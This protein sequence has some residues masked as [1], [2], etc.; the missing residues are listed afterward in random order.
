MPQTQHITLPQNDPFAVAPQAPLWWSLPIF[1]LMLPVTLIGVFLAVIACIT[2]V[3]LFPFL[4]GKLRDALAKV[5]T[6]TL[7]AAVRVRMRVIDHNPDPSHHAKLFVAPHIFMFEAI[8]MFRIVGHIR[9]LAAAFVKTIPVFN[10]V[11]AAV[12]PIYVGRS[13]GGNVV[14]RLRESLE[15]TDYRHAIFPEGT[16]TNGDTIIRFKS[17]AFAAGHP[18]TPV[19]FRYPDYVPFWN[20]TESSLFM[21]IYRLLSRVQTPVTAEI[22]PTYFPSAAEIADP[23]LYAENVRQLISAATGR[24]LSECSLEDSPNYKK[25]RKNGH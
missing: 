18:I 3:P 22:L 8:M 6:G 16:F 10:R 1:L 24:A 9:P 17:G 11:I 5:V 13:K 21:Q 2:L 7:I 4:A 19:I 23:S 14:K 20:R 12:D 25:D 15:T